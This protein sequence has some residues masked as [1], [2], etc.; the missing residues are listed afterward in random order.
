[1]GDTGDERITGRKTIDLVDD[2]KAVDVDTYHRMSPGA[3]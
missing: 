1:M 2:V 3:A